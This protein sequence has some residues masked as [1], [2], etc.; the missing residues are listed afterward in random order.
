[1]NPI[2]YARTTAGLSK[3]QLSAKMRLSRTFILRAEEGCYTNPGTKL[4]DFTCSTLQISRGEFRRQYR[5]FQSE[6]RK[7]AA[8]TLEPLQ[9]PNRVKSE[10]TPVGPV[11]NSEDDLEHFKTVYFHKVFK[12]W[13]EDYWASRNNAASALC[14]HPAS[15]ENYEEG[16]YK[17]MPELIKEALQEVKL[18]D[19]S[20]DPN[21]EWC[22]VYS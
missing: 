4:I 19:E 13:R 12:S 16:A 10:L 1:M 5:H 7:R 2:T 8:E 11:I 17:Q 20:F 15:I 6:Q 18:L 22:Y 3:H 21:A 9:V 14:L